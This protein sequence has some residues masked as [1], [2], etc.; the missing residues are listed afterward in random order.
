MSI[1][2]YKL[3]SRVKG[4][5]VCVDYNDIS[6]LPQRGEILYNTTGLAE[7]IVK[8]DSADNTHFLFM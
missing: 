7:F 2:V 1:T 6:S 8:A 3:H 4:T 5:V